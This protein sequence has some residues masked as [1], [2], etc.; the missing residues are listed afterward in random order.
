MINGHDPWPWLVVG[1]IPYTLKQQFLTDGTRLL[2]AHAFFWSA[3]IRLS[4]KGR[5]QWTIRIPLIERLR[6]TLWEVLMR[7]REDEPD[8]PQQE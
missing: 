3:E 5:T 8:E 1:M 6:N 2:Q 7:L 4:R